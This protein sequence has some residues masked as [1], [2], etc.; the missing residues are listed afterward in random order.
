MLGTIS[1]VVAKMALDRGLATGRTIG[2]IYAG[3][4][5]HACS[6]DAFEK[7]LD[8]CRELQLTINTA[9]L[10]YNLGIALHNLKGDARA[11]EHMQKAADGFGAAIK[12]HPNSAGLYVKLADALKR[13]GDPN[14][15]ADALRRAIELDPNESSNY[16][17]L[18]SILELE[19][20]FDEAIATLNQ[21]MTYLKENQRLEEAKQL[22]EYGD[23]LEFRRWNKS[24][25]TTDTPSSSKQYH[26]AA[27]DSPAR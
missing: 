13:S 25:T 8:Y 1:P 9:K 19:E 7:A 6:A 27:G 21:L 15:A 5:D 20:D 23:F 22:K 18:L 26:K 10:H 4:G 3:Q 17:S 11:K 24:R 16:A 2:M 14:S 12:R